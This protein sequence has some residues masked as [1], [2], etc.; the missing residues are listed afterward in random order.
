MQPLDAPGDGS[1]PASGTGTGLGVNGAAAAEGAALL[2]VSGVSKAFGGVQ[3]LT[4][5]DFD[6]RAGEVHSL[7]GENGAGKSTLVKVVSGVHRADQGAVLLG[8]APFSP[9]DPDESSRRGLGVVFQELPLVPD[10]TVMENIYFNRQPRTVLGT[11][12]RRKMRARTTALF[13][14][15]GLSG[16]SAD[17]EVRDL[18]VAGRQFVAIAKVLADDP[19]LVVFDEATSALGPS[20]VAWLLDRMKLLAAS[21]KGI[22]FISHR[23]AEIEEISDRVTVLRNGQSVGTWPM[24][25]VAGDDLVSAMLG[26]QLEQLYPS[27]RATP[28]VDVVL[29]VRG[30]SAGRRLRGVDLV[31]RRG[32]ILGICGLEGQGQLELFLALFGI[33]RSQGTVTVDGVTQRIRSPEDAIHAGIGIAL[34]PEDRKNEGILPT[35][36][37]RENLTLPSLERLTRLG[38]ITAAHERRFVMPLIEELQIGR[39]DPEQLAG[40]LSGGNQ[41]KVVVGKFLLA[42]AKV[43]LVYD[44]TRGVDVG[45]KAEIFRKLEELAEEGYG[46]LFYS[47]DLAELVNVPHRVQVMFDGAFVGEFVHGSFDQEELVSAMVGRTGR[48]AAV[49]ASQPPPASIDASAAR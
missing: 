27:R 15:L 16:V 44:L 18:S 29:G 41:Q 33:L 8:G 38:F 28:G 11:V 17:S 10:M 2:V 42:G 45:T 3:A 4:E 43:L 13:E 31:V 14:E 39:R 46:V 1:S 19:A 34:V 21:G 23:L 25:E 30:L 12:A 47:S 6:V 7:L 9:R 35:L 32:E 5:V 20:E 36:S 26:R 48:A 22:V 49:M 24:G 37:I 40:G